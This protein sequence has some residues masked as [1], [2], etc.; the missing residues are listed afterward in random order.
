MS[1]PI[2]DKI[3]SNYY[4][5][6]ITILFL[7][8]IYIGANGTVNRFFSMSRTLCFYPFFVLGY[9]NKK[10]N[11]FGFK[12]KFNNWLKLIAIILVIVCF[13]LLIKIYPISS[14]ALYMA[15]PY[16][17]PYHTAIHRLIIYLFA[18]T[19]VVLLTSL[20]INHKN[21]FVEFISKN[22][23]TIFLFHGFLINI[24]KYLNVLPNFNISI[25]ISILLSFLALI[26]F[27]GVKVLINHINSKF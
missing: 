5:L 18:S 20:S 25:I 17:G 14:A 4:S 26:F 21:R 9:F 13:G 6:V 8:G 3:S 1:L 15:D 2:L 22:T 24:F 19:M 16:S 10:S 11:N 27:A 23:L 12:L 7:F